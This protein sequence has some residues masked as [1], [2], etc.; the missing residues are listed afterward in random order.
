MQKSLQKSR[1]KIHQKFVTK[2]QKICQ[3]NRQKKLSKKFVKKFV[4]KTETY[5]KNQS[6]RTEAKEPR[7]QQQQH[8]SRFLKASLVR[9]ADVKRT[10]SGRQA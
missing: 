5:K 2:V 10:A 8:K 7:L 4:K 9:Q 6:K 3:K 1:Q